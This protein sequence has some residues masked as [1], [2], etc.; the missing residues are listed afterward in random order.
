V[1]KTSGATPR[2]TASQSQSVRRSRQDEADIA[3]SESLIRRE[4][5]IPLKKILKEFG[6]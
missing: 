3:V 2:A 4:K 1:S 6:R 5:P